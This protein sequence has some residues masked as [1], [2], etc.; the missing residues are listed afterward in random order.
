MQELVD[1][2]NLIGVAAFSI[3]GALAAGR[4]HMDLFGV[5][6]VGC[7][8][9][10]GGGTLRDVLMGSYPI[11]WIAAP[12][13]F[14]IAALAAACTFFLARHRSTAPRS[15][16][17]VDAA[18]LALF[19]LIGFQK[20]YAITQLYSVGIIMGVVTGVAGGIVRDVL[21]NEIPLIFRREI[22]A[23]SS[24]FGAILL[25]LSFRFFDENIIAVSISV[26]SILAIRLAAIRWKLSMPVFVLD[27]EG[28][29]SA[30]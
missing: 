21:C 2:L 15:V 19:T 27:D 25:A 5:V 22:Y 17:Y 9:A 24:L 10:L 1:I 14:M 4:K 18:G 11:F 28:R 20:G 12:H 6:V 8:T 26:F 3:A 7:V 29:E 13:N 23:S 16:M 30:G